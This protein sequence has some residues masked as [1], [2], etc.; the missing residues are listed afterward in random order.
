MQVVWSGAMR[1]EDLGQRELV[2][3]AKQR[4]AAAWSAIYSEHYDSMYRYLYSR[5]GKKEEAEDLASQVFL[6]ALQAIDS[7]VDMGKPLGAWLFGIARNLANNSVRRSRRLG[8]TESLESSDVETELQTL[9]R[10][11]NADSLDLMTG[12][13]DLPKE[14]REAVI[15]RF[16]VGL[17]ARETGK[18]MGKSE[19]AVYALQ[20]RAISALRR[21]VGDGNDKGKAAA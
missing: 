11:L 7:F 3:L 19:L 16:F 2:T 20:V 10:R 12:L 6:E 21:M 8:Q 14:Q 4:D 13:N 15:L 5:L 1:R 17:S 18:V 9:P